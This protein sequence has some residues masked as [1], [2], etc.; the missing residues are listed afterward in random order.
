MKINL[1]KLIDADRIDEIIDVLQPLCKLA[2]EL[3]ELVPD[4]SKRTEYRI[5][6][7]KVQSVLAFIDSITDNDDDAKEDA[8]RELFRS[9]VSTMAETDQISKEGK[10]ALEGDTPATDDSL[11]DEEEVY[12]NNN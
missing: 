12:P 1:L 10:L 7:A 2:G 4:R 11:A 8:S 6:V 3:I 9:L 5:F